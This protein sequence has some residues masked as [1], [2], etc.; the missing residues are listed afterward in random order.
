MSDLLDYFYAT[1]G[2]WSKAEEAVERFEAQQLE[3]K[4]KED[5]VKEV[6]K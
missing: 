2:S 6:S 3:K 1:L 5:S 4:L